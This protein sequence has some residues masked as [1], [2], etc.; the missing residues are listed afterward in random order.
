MTL[1]AREN[2]L[3]IDLFSA[4]VGFL[5][6]AATAGCDSRLMLNRFFLA[7]FRKWRLYGIHPS[8]IHLGHYMLGLWGV[9]RNIVPSCTDNS[10]TFGTH[11][12]RY[13]RQLSCQSLIPNIPLQKPEPSWNGAV[14]LVT[15]CKMAC[16]DWCLFKRMISG[17]VGRQDSWSTA[18]MTSSAQTLSQVCRSASPFGI[19][20]AHLIPTDFYIWYHLAYNLAFVG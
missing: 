5:V 4:Q 18:N 9:K 6:S 17:C 10:P 8:W 1:L 7:L 12:D 2:L 15:W 13:F 11:P 16:S 20:S 14:C 3:K 19:S